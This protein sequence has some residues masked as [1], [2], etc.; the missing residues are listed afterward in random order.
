M[1]LVKT[2]LGITLGAII[3]ALG[4]NA[5][6]VANHLAEGGVTGASLIVFY[7]TGYPFG[8]V[9]L[10]MNIPLFFIG[11]WLVGWRF[12]VRTL[13]GVAVV[14]V[15]SQLTQGLAVNTGDLLLA[16]LYA[17][18]VTGLGLGIIFRFGGTAGGVDILARILWQYRGIEMGKTIFSLDILVMGGFALL[19]GKEVAMYSLVAMFI[20]SRV[21]DF[22]QEGTFTAKAVT[23][24]S[25]QPKP[26]AEAI[27]NRLKRGTT[28]LRGRGGYTD[29]ER[30][31]LYVI[32]S[33]S[34]I[35][36]LKHLVNQIDPKAFMV[37]S[38]AREVLGEG[39]GRATPD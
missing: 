5:F 2:Y 16:A 7:L 28:L 24:I 38:D 39:F 13:Y 34:E 9:L 10:L 1:H 27:M 23:I 33:R 22:V 12:A 37:V 19:F 20:A 25:D 8:L 3:F 31:V 35:G 32:V 30:D 17:G 14:A 18:A 21:I 15:T 11:L 6:V 36:R 4:L 26:I 29:R